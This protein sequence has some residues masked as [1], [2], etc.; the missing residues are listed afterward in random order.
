MPGAWEEVT[1]DDVKDAP[2]SYMPAAAM[3]GA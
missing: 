3:V 2:I 1:F